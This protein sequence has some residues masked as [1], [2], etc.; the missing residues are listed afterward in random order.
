MISKHDS[1]LVRNYKINKLSLTKAY[2][3]TV[4]KVVEWSLKLLTSTP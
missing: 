4:K 3:S 1:Q 2:Y